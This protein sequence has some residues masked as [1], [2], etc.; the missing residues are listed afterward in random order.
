M[1]IKKILLFTFVWHW[2]VVTSVWAQ[3]NLDERVWLNDNDLVYNK[4]M[5]NLRVDFESYNIPPTWRV[6]RD[7]FLTQVR[8]ER[9]LLNP[10]SYQIMRDVMLVLSQDFEDISVE[11][12]WNQAEQYMHTKIDLI[13][14]ILALTADDF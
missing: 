2:L 6:Y 1:T 11:G 14:N 5:E 13:T 8:E 3:D 4:V 10:T 7:A 9:Q 12:S